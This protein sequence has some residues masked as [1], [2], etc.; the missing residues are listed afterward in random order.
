MAREISLAPTAAVEEPAAA[1]ARVRRRRQLHLFSVAA[2]VHKVNV[3]EWRER[4]GGA[5]AGAHRIGPSQHVVLPL[6]SNSLMQALVSSSLMQAFSA[7]PCIV[8][9]ARSYPCKTRFRG[10]F[11]G[12]Q[13]SRRTARVQ[14]ERSEESRAAIPRRFH[15]DVEELADDARAG[16]R[17][18]GITRFLGGFAMMRRSRR[19]VRALA[20][21]SEESRAEARASEEVSLRCREAGVWRA[22]VVVHECRWAR[23]TQLPTDPAHELWGKHYMGQPTWANMGRPA[24][25]EEVGEEEVRRLATGDT[26]TTSSRGGGCRGRMLGGSRRLDG[27]EIDGVPLEP[28]KRQHS[29]AL[30]DIGSGGRHNN[31]A[32]YTVDQTMAAYTATARWLLEPTITTPQRVTK[33]SID[34]AFFLRDPYLHSIGRAVGH[35]IDGGGGSEELDLT[36]EADIAVADLTDE[37]KVSLGRRFWSFFQACPVV[38]RWLTRLTVD[39]CLSG[40]DDIPTLV[41]TCGRLRFLELRHCDVVDDAVLEIDAPRSQLVC[42]KLHH[43]NFRRMDLIQVPKL[44]RVRFGYVPCLGNIAFGS[45]CLFWHEPFVLSQFGFKPEDPK[46]LSP[47]FGNLRDVHLRNIFNGC[48][49][50]WTLFLLDAAPSFNSMYILLCRHTCEACECE[51]GAEKTNVTRKTSDFK[52]HNLSLLEMKGFEVEK[53]RRTDR[54]QQDEKEK[55]S[56]IITG[57]A[58]HWRVGSHCLDGGSV[59]AGSGVEDGELVEADEAVAAGG[60]VAEALEPRD[61]AVAVVVELDEASRRRRSLPRS[62]PPPPSPSP[63]SSRP[64]PFTAASNRSPLQGLT[65]TTAEAAKSAALAGETPSSAA[66][67]ATDKLRRR[68]TET[69]VGGGLGRRCS[70]SPWWRRRGEARVRRRGR[71]GGGGA[72]EEKEARRMGGRRRRGGAAKRKRRVARK[73]G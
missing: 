31:A 38:F 24:R 36:V 17:K 71:R 33:K 61:L 10:C 58:L 65:R 57:F 16:G 44:R 18:R 7:K 56:K 59:A 21:G 14:L 51:Y 2:E 73:E 29:V 30:P 23:S 49:L 53:R 72:V 34:L 3:G 32:G 12:K 48:D 5:D 37:H 52:H 69:D 1:P 26:A 6:V 63:P 13:K 68:W 40:P 43:C 8:L 27:G 4:G 50:N 54:I 46:L 39:D 9:I 20:G 22:L 62:G 42:L 66:N 60:C 70:R 41:N 35:A 25:G 47:I 55:E 19:T 45:E 64:R 67:T 11:M 28:H 15:W